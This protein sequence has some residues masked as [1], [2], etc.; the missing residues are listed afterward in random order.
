MVGKSPDQTP[1]PQGADPTR[2]PT[3]KSLSL[4]QRAFSRGTTQEQGE[5]KDSGVGRLLCATRMRLGKDL[6]YIGQVLHIR[7]TYLVA[8]EDGRYED[9][10]G[11]A[12]A[13]GFVRAYADHLGLDGDEVV[14]RFKEE[15]TGLRRKAALDFPIPTPD[16]GIPSGLSLLGAVL[17]GMAVYGTWYAISRPTRTFPLVQEVPTRLTAA[18]ESEEAAAEPQ[19]PATEAAA[20]EIPGEATPPPTGPTVPTDTAVET[21]VPEQTATLSPPPETP[22]EPPDVLELRAK[23]DS[24]IQVRKGDDILLT[25]LLK[26]GDTYRV[27]EPHGLTLMTANAGSLDVLVNG[28]VTVPLG[29]SGAVASGIPLEVDHFKLA[30]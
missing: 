15:S 1:P 5:F 12:Y 20:G 16:S 6:Q 27:P 19:Q 3:D 30:E 2:P 8:I 7:Y 11:Q 10:P 14:R 21:Q 28:E 22:V 18:K 4:F 25:R 29:D 9:L 17:L 24:W 23:A 26:K 13:I